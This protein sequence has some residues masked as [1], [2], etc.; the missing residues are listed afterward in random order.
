M[1]MKDSDLVYSVNRDGKLFLKD[2]YVPDD[3]H[4]R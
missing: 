1:M 2:S 4:L 3:A